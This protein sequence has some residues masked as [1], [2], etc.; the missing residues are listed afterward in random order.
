MGPHFRAGV[1]IVVERSDGM[2][3]AFER[4]D[5]PGSWQLPQGG[6]DAGESRCEAAWRELGEETGLGAG[7]VSLIGEH[8]E[9]TV[10]ELPTAYQRGSRLGQAHR[11]FRFRVLDDA[12]EPTP[13]G[14]EF[15]AWQWMAPVE[16]VRLTAPFRQHGYSTVLLGASDE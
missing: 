7:Q 5:A 1:I 3:L 14:V 2:V 13:D 8:P 11:W 12:V 15:G 10:Y 9:W 16:L 4:C 6:I